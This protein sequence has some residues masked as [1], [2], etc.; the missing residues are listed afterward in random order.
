MPG[1]PLWSSLETCCGPRASEHSG[2]A[3]RGWQV[4]GS[5]REMSRGV[6]AGWLTSC[7]WGK[8]CPQESAGPS[9]QTP[10]HTQSPHC[11]GR[12]CH[13]WRKFSL[14]EKKQKQNTNMTTNKQHLLGTWN[15]KH[16]Q[17][18]FPQLPCLQPQPEHFFKTFLHVNWI[19]FEYCGGKHFQNLG[20]YDFC[21]S[22]RAR[23]LMSYVALRWVPGV[24]CRGWGTTHRHSSLIS[25]SCWADLIS[26]PAECCP[27]RNRTQTTFHELAGITTISWS[28]R[29]KMLQRLNP[30]L[31]RNHTW[32]RHHDQ[33]IG[34]FR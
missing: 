24:G 6:R 22:R 7:P 11:Q 14:E 8:G 20:R 33:L 1:G 15:T 9:E 31:T 28:R 5:R 13:S 21:H 19:S 27:Q 26:T 10:Y 17:C 18:E 3:W 25:V 32:T 23:V 4:S 16:G 29:H 34:H 30:V 12:G 2:P